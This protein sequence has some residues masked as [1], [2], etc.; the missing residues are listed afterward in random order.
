FMGAV[1]DQRFFCALYNIRAVWER[2]YVNAPNRFASVELF[3]H[4][5]DELFL[6]RTLDMSTFGS[7]DPESDESDS[8]DIPNDFGAPTRLIDFRAVRQCKYL[9]VYGLNKLWTMTDADIVEWLHSETT[10]TWW[11]NRTRSLSVLEGIEDSVGLREELKK[12]WPEE[13]LHTNET[14]KEQL[15]IYAHTS[16]N[17]VVE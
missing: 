6:C 1:I 15:R 7:I 5:F 14:T 11:P 2:G 12:D 8:D 16:E 4:A 9:E 3:R 10:E 17:L 13:E